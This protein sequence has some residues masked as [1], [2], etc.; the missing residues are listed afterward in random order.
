MKIKDKKQVEQKTIEDNTLG[1][2]VWDYNDVMDLSSAITYALIDEK[3]IIEKNNNKTSTHI[4]NHFPP[5][6]YPFNVEDT[7]REV[8]CKR[9]KIKEE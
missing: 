1:I 7:I 8:I 4:V 9:F 3:L 5:N 2:G 6:N